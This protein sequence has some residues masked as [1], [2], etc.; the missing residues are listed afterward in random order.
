MTRMIQRTEVRISID[1]SR[2]GTEK[3]SRIFL[4]DEVMKGAA[5]ITH[6]AAKTVT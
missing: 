6:A 5:E 4:R 1:C 3:R 2:I